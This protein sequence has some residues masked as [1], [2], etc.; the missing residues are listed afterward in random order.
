MQFSLS[1]PQL[2]L[3][4]TRL[5]PSE[6]VFTPLIYIIARYRGELRTVWEHREPPAILKQDEEDEVAGASVSKL[7]EQARVGSLRGGK[8]NAE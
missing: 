3:N 8:D 6:S 7:Q 5:R 1:R 4:L 2:D